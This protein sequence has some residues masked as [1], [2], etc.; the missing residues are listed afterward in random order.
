[1]CL[2]PHAHTWIAR[3]ARVDRFVACGGRHGGGAG[4]GGSG[5][6]GMVWCCVA[7]P[8]VSSNTQQQ[9][10]THKTHNNPHTR[11]NT[12]P[13]CYAP[14]RFVLLTRRPSN[15]VDPPTRVRYFI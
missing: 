2:G 14:A 4:G 3:T 15:P 10:K 12:N 5:G 9:Q 13:G 7:R 6:G 1:M 8:C 11:T